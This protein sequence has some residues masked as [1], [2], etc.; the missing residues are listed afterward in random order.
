[1][2]NKK[3]KI[4]DIEFDNISQEQL[5]ESKTN[6]QIT[7]VNVDMLM[8]SQHDKEFHTIINNSS[9]VICDSKLLQLASKFLNTPIIEKISGSDFFPTF[10]EYHK[11]NHNITIFL[12]GSATQATVEKAQHNINT[13][14]EKNIIIEALSPSFGFEENEK[15]NLE[16]IQKINDSKASVLA[17]GVGSPKQ[18]KWL[19]KYKSQLPNIK[20]FLPIGATID[21]EAGNIQRAPKWMSNIGLEWFYRLANEPKRLWKRYLIEDMP[22]FLLILKQK[23]GFY[24]NPWKGDK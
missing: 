7:P 23:F 15:E 4:L 9:Y 13:R 24:T 18:E 16:I 6:G 19:A 20:I 3:I 5:L 14:V 21:F 11:K 10:C 17:I 1:M 12:L 22:F 8:K 2:N